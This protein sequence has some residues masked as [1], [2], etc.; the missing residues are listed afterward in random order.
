MEDQMT[1][2]NK[3]H[4]LK[5]RLTDEED[6]TIRANSKLGEMTVSDFV[7]YKVFGD[8]KVS[9]CP[10]CGGDLFDSVISMNRVVAGEPTQKNEYYTTCYKCGW[11]KTQTD[12]QDYLDGKMPD[13][14]D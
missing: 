3:D 13:P 14:R 9:V 7:R 6:K 10:E 5:I 4:F 8:H 1:K 2:S 11:V 12:Y